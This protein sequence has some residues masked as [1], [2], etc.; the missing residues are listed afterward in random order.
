MEIDYKNSGGP[1]PMRSMITKQWA[2]IYNAW[3]DGERVYQNNNEGM[4][5][6]A[7]QEAA[8]TNSVLEERLNTCRIRMPEE[9]YNIQKDP[10]CMHNLINDPVYKKQLVQLRKDFEKWLIKIKDPLLKVFQNRE[11]TTV[12]LKEFYKAYPEAEALDKDKKNYSKNTGQ[13]AD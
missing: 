6:S 12:A 3:A 8:K 4:T 11:N 9:L 1:T 13:R 10:D 7:I 5:M 2:Y